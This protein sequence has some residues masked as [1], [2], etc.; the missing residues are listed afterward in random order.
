DDAGNETSPSFS[1][2]V[3]E[4]MRAASSISG[5]VGF[6]DIDNV[7]VTA[8]GQAE[9]ARGQAV[10]GNYY[11]AL[12]VSPILGHPFTPADDRENSD[13]VCLI[14]Y[15]YWEKRFA[16]DPAVA[17]ARVAI[18]GVPFTIAGV[19]PRDFLGLSTGDAP[20]ITVPF[21]QLAK[22]LPHFNDQETSEFLDSSY[23]W[24]ETAVRLK[25]GVS[26]ATARAEL[27][28]LLQHA[29]T[30]PLGGS[31]TPPELSL[32][33]PGEGLNFA[34]TRY[35]YPL[36]ILMSIVAVV[37]LV[38]CANVAN[39]LLA[40]AQ[41]REKE[42]AMRLALGAGRARLAR[43]LLTESVL[44]AMLGA[45]PAVALAY[46]TS[47][48]LAAF[49]GLALDVRPDA[50]ILAF[51]AAVTLGTGILFGLA[52]ALRL[53]RA[54]LQPSLQRN[55]RASRFSMSRILVIAQ[56][57][58]A[59]MVLVGA[60]LYS[61]TLDNLRHVDL[62]LNPDHL[63]VFRLIPALAGYSDARA[64]D[65]DTQV[66]AALEQIPGV[67]SAGIS[68]HIP[69]SGSTRT[70]FITVPGSP[71]FSVE[72]KNIVAVNLASSHFFDAMGIPILLGRAVDDRDRAG[73]P[74]A[75]VINERLARVYFPNQSP[76]GRHFQV[77]EDG[78]LDDFEIVGVARDSKYNS[79]RRAAPPTFFMSYLQSSNDGGN[80][81]F[82]LRTIGDPLAIA[83]NVRRAVARL[84][85]NVPV[86]QLGTE[87]EQIDG[88]ISQDRL[89]AGLSTAFGALALLLAA[90]GLY[91][92]R[93]YSVARRIPEI[94]IRMAL[95]A[96]R[97]MIILMILR[98]TG[99]LALIGVAIG[100]AGSFAVTRY[101]QSMLYGVAPRDF[102]TFALATLILVA[103]AALASFLP[104]R[105]ASR[106]EPLTALRRD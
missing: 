73:A 43:Q 29:I 27:N 33:A 22:I 38:A 84:D 15:R 82:E 37:L 86:F 52:P 55:E 89:F 8:N 92:V 81:A 1:Y 58:L 13:P 90:I 106:I 34:R 7:G 69:L 100:L 79:I 53:A 76:V 42:T 6:A 104:A 87:E 70:R 97:G 72:Q 23:W 12:G 11:S 39:L 48:I 3:F 78:R 4:S 93:A 75:A 74:L 14:S 64:R 61:R 21:H 91:G 51:T 80:I 2:P 41:S 46:W 16:L 65:F 95:G 36:L 71:K 19:E 63:L 98:E 40:H 47:S 32:G 101:L 45:I 103:V 17:G 99:W 9:I 66:A 102:T 83:A 60:G 56:L 67:Q 26:P 57:A 35:R 105:R 24:V 30:A 54:D 10:S 50:R 44:L 77:R 25:P 31:P 85:A 18:N 68:R 94:G 5:A 20:D 59:L 96:D 88:L 49:N 28:V 62:G